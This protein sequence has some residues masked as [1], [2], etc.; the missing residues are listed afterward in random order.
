[1]KI[2][3]IGLLWIVPA[4]LQAGA[5]RPAS[6]PVD[7]RA[8]EMME[9]LKSE[10]KADANSF[11][12]EFLK[13]VP[14]TRLEDLCHSM[15]LGTV[16][17]LVP[18]KVESEWKGSFDIQFDGRVAIP[19]NLSVET[20]APHRIE[21]LWFG[22][23]RTIVKSLADL[24]ATFATFPGTVSFGVAR[25][26]EDRK[27]E[28]E[29]MASHEPDTALGIGSAFKLYILGALVEEI[30]LGKRKWSDV[31]VL[32]TDYQSFPS[33]FLQSWPAGAPITLH[34]LATL[35][36]SQSDNTATD[37]LL[38][39]LGR[40]RVESMLEKMGN[41]HAERN[42]PFLSTLEVFKL[43]GKQ[44][45]AL[46]KRYAGA[47]EAARR[48]ILSKDVA[49]IARDSVDLSSYNVKPIAI[50]TLEW[51]A[52]AG[53][54][55]RAMRWLLDHSQSGDAAAMRGVLSVNPGLAIPPGA[56]V[57]NGFKGGSETGVLN[58]T[59]CFTTKTGARY[60][61]AATWNNP[62]APV[63]DA[64]FVAPV[65]SAIDLLGNLVSR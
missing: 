58:L 1:M 44:Q 9:L 19:M 21:G 16:R 65:Q 6:R 14:T 17:V 13:A 32:R 56:F 7:T 29:W 43:K 15:V 52:S 10:S 55:A 41:R 60:A 39:L 47:T 31:T 50:E 37:H 28:V 46:R 62:A 48:E 64:A 2:L 40:E 25:L 42:R 24:P 30:E 49:A 36:I 11:T 63:Q 8:Y 33:G 61:V 38:F 54:L 51:F 4:A 59:F 20:T 27:S 45:K 12:P 3:A 18:V 22:P 57:Y 26:P 23:P 34:S 5:S 35:M 53:D